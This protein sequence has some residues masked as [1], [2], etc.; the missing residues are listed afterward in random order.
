MIKIL[1]ESKRSGSL[2]ADETGNRIRPKKVARQ[3]G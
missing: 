3:K 1:P 2:D